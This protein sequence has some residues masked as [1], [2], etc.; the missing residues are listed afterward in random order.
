MQTT[1]VVT[2]TLVDGDTITL[3]ELLPVQA[4]R[5]RLVVEVEPI[6]TGAQ[7][8]LQAILAAI[9]ARQSARRYR[10]PTRDEIDRYLEHERAS[11]E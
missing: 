3:D 7:R 6:E 9:R 10:P 11:W 8:P 5:V 4:Q 1:Y 2:G